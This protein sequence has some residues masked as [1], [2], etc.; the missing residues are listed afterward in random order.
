MSQKYEHRIHLSEASHKK[1]RQGLSAVVKHSSIGSAKAKCFHCGPETHAKLMH[2]F[3]NKTPATI[4]LSAEEIA[5]NDEQSGT[6]F[7]RTLHKLGVSKKQ[8]NKGGKKIVKGLKTVGIAVAKEALP[9]LAQGIVTAGATALSEN[10]VIGAV[11]GKVANNL[12]KQ[13]VS[14]LGNGLTVSRSRNGLKVSRSRISVMR[15]K[16]MAVALADTVNGNKV[17]MGLPMNQYDSP[18]IHTGLLGITNVL[19]HSHPARN[20]YIPQTQG[21]L[22]QAVGSGIYAP[23]R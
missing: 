16:P 7:F 14:K 9:V 1:L 13:Q 11:A 23:G 20:P 22:Y 6:G 12:V 21:V 4:Q 17:G 3:Q 5:M 8:F 2:A 15:K 18:N 10:P 19:N